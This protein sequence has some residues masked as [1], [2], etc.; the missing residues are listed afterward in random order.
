MVADAAAKL[1]ALVVGNLRTVRAR[2]TIAAT[3]VV[4]L[5]LGVGAMFLLS[6]LNTRLIENL[7]SSS[8]TPGG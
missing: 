4:T 7:E 2:T 1:L 8:R 3:G 5:A 6:V